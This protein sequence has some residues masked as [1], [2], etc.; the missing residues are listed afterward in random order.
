MVLDLKRIFAT[1]NSVLQIEHTLDM[2][3]VDF[4]GNF[5]SKIP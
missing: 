1:D 2:S 5:R 4:M 3:D